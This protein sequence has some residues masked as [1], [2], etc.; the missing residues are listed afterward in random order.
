[1]DEAASESR[2]YLSFTI[3]LLAMESM[4]ARA[5][6][7]SPSPSLGYF[8]GNIP[9]KP[10]MVRVNAFIRKEIDRARSLSTLF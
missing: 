3:L 8:Y 5:P 4:V 10:S 6:I 2:G 1:M 9:F 7:L